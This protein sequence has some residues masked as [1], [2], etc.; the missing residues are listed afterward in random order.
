MPKITSI[1]LALCVSI[2]ALVLFMASVHH[3]N[4]V[5]PLLGYSFAVTWV[6]LS[7]AVDRPSN[8]SRSS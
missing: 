4:A 1:L 7:F 2:F 3:D 6:A 8:A 5:F